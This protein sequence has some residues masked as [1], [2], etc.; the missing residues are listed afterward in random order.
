MKERTGHSSRG[1]DGS[2]NGKLL[3]IVTSRD[4]QCPDC[5]VKLDSRVHDTH[6]MLF[7]VKKASAF[8]KRIILSG[9]TKL[10]NCRF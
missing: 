8:L 6:S 2:A 7:T 9:I 3:G 4:Y 1:D 10:I 5:R